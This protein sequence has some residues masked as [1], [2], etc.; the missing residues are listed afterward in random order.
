MTK[1]MKKPQV[2]DDEDMDISPSVKATPLQTLLEQDFF[3]NRE[4]FM[5][6]EFSEETVNALS[7]QI[8][9]HS[10]IADANIG[11]HNK[12]L[13]RKM[14]AEDY[15]VVLHINSYG[16]S[17]YELLRLYDLIRAAPFKTDTVVH[18]KLQE[19]LLVHALR[20]LVGKFHHGVLPVLRHV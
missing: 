1:T 16:G 12:E 18:G 10:R 17:I 9:M 13:N 5:D 14:T 20:Q 7:Q 6:K 15:R 11:R 19:V 8:L 4:L 2:H 3:G